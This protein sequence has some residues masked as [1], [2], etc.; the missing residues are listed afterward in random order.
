MK[1]RGNLPV[2]VF[3]LA[4]YILF[5]Q[6]IG[7][8]S[9]RRKTAQLLCAILFLLATISTLSQRYETHAANASLTALLTQSSAARPIQHVFIV[10][11]DVM[12]P[13]SYTEPDAHGLK[14]PP[15]R[16]MVLHGM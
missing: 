1:P 12:K 14:I 9:M 16:E 15:L 13:E 10:S 11:I 7:G 3:R 4:V 2:L 5:E 8:N 6:I